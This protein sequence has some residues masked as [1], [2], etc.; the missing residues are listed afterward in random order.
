MK[1]EK[2]IGEKRKKGHK[3]KKKKQDQI[4]D[5]NNKLEISTFA[6]SIQNLRTSTAPQFAAK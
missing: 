6:F 3:K 5:T 2:K 1:Q 4:F